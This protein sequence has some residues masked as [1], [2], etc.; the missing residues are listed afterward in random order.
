MSAGAQVIDHESPFTSQLQLL[1]LPSALS[2]SASPSDSL[3]QEAG[4]ASE[5][6][7]SPN[8]SA[9]N[10]RITDS[11]TAPTNFSPRRWRKWL[12]SEASKNVHAPSSASAGVLKR[13]AKKAVV[14]NSSNQINRLILNS[15]LIFQ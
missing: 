6:T 15:N 14:P 3:W 13:F 8:E 11:L 1:L 10:F 12:S 2:R 5:A 4:E 9:R 7:S